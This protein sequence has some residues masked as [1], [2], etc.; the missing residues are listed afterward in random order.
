MAAHPPSSKL[1]RAYLIVNFLWIQQNQ[2]SRSSRMKNW[3]CLSTANSLHPES[4]AFSTVCFSEQL[5]FSSTFRKHE[6]HKQRAFL[7]QLLGSPRVRV[8][9][10]MSMWASH[11]GLWLTSVLCASGCPVPLPLGCTLSSFTL[12]LQTNS[13]LASFR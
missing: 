8:G 6:L 4:L 12:S 2:V 10:H 11:S 5:K 1:G 13:D 9:E 7:A 3:G